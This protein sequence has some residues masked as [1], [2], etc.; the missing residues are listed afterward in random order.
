MW[1]FP[2]TGHVRESGGLRQW[3][4]R[5]KPDLHDPAGICGSFLG[6]GL[7]ALGL[8]SRPWVGLGPQRHPRPEGSSD[9]RNAAA[10]AARLATPSFARMFETWFLTVFVCRARRWAISLLE[11]PSTI[12]RRISRSRRVRRASPA[13]SRRWLA[14]AA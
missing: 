14:R 11:S 7:G 6:L 2:T 8:S 1:P 5:L 3:A 4:F 9:P 13:G 12:S 10:A